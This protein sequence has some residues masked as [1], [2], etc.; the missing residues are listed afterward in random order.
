M[1]NNDGRIVNSE[2][3]VFDKLRFIEFVSL[4]VPYIS[5]NLQEIQK[6]LVFYNKE[7]Y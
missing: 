5:I 4:Y 1:L 2:V 3:N 6:L 7:G